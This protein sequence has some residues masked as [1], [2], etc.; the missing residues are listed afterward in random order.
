MGDRADAARQAQTRTSPVMTNVRNMI[1]TE[2]GAAGDLVLEMA[3][4]RKRD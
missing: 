2:V 3:L 1:M 4:P